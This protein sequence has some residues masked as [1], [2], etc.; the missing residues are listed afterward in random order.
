MNRGSGILPFVPV[1]LTASFM[2]NVRVFVQYLYVDL[3]EGHAP[4]D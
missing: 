1:G 3:V 4:R 2:S